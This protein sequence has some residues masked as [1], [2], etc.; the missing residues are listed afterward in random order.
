MTKVGK[1]LPDIYG[2]AI[3][4]L[5]VM[6]FFSLK[7]LLHENMGMANEVD[8][9]PLAKQYADPTWIPG[10]W[11][12]NQPPGYRLLFETL[13]GRLIVTWGFLATS[14]IGRLL[15]YGLVAS[16]LVL[17]GRRLGLS[18]P[19]L[20]LAVVLF[21]S[22]NRNQG[23]VAFEWLLGGLEA[24]SVAYGFVLLAIALMLM[25]MYRLMAL[26]LGLATSFHVLIGGWAFLATLGWLVLRWKTRLKGIGQIGVLLGIYLLASAFAIKP[27]LEQ[28]FTTLPPSSVTPSYIYVFVRLPHHLNPLSWSSDWWIKPAIYLLV[29]VMSIKLLQRQQHSDRLSKQHTAQI[30]LFEF[31]L[32]CL[33]PFILGVAVAPLD[34]EGRLLQYYPFRLGDVMLPLNTCLIFACA[35]Q[36]TFTGRTRQVL[37][38]FCI[39][40]LTVLCSIQSVSFHKQFLGLRQFPHVDPEFKA[41]CNW[42]RTQTLTDATVISPP[43]DFVDFTW[44]AER[45]TIANFKLLPQTKAG[46][47]EW[48]DRLSDLSGNFSPWSATTRTKNSKR[49]IKQALIAGYNHLTTTQVD[50]LMTKYRATYFM[51]RIEHQLDLPSAYHNSRY[52]LYSRKN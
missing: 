19:L 26:M 38:L 51:T 36:Q 14:M 43:V 6:G 40:L 28:L 20:L 27:V 2:T 31:T 18:L 21:L 30:E 13:F 17:I 10:D 33:V 50:A 32:I 37:L 35:L 52:V 12:L 44:L 5:V 41:L 25:G 49:E 34:Y 45:P 11:Y 23:L 42:V 7:F 1:I 48:Y 8:V 9:L 46:I 24:K 15:C 47:L 4:V 3:Q 22:T 29:L 16:G 39:V